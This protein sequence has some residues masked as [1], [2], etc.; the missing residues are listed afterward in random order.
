M[1]TDDANRT[2][3]RIS[4]DPNPHP[5]E[6]LAALPSPAQFGGPGLVFAIPRDARTLFTYWNI[7][8]G[9]AFAAHEP[10]DRNVYLRVL[11][12]NN[13]VETESVVEPLL[14][15]FY[16]PVKNPRGKYRADLGYYTRADD[17]R[18][19]GTSEAVTMPADSPSENTVVDVATVPFHLSF[20]KLIDLFCQS[21][22]DPLA[23]ALAKV[24][25]QA[26]RAGQAQDVDEL[27]PNEREVLRAMNLSLDELRMAREMFA[28]RPDEKTLRK[29]AEAILGFG[30]TSPAHGFGDSSSLAGGFGGSSPGR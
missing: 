19:V 25:Q 23:V 9:S 18:S 28:D 4:R 22:G 24:Q 7:D 1:A 2:G 17:W 10:K 5:V 3:F 6:E 8:W 15:S 13:N 12:E 11:R 26:L 21:N 14:G 16:A 27:T 20:Q 29:R 30:T